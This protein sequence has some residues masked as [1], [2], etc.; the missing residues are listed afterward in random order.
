MTTKAEF[1][2]NELVNFANSFRFS[3]GQ[4]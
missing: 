1:K 2:I 4:D 3:F